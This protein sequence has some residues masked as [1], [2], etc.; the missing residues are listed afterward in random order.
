MSEREQRERERRYRVWERAD[1]P[2][3]D[4]NGVINP[5]RQMRGN[6]VTRE[7]TSMLRQWLEPEDVGSAGKLLIALRAAG[8]SAGGDEPWRTILEVVPALDRDCQ[9]HAVKHPPSGW[10]F[11][12]RSCGQRLR[13]RDDAALHQLGESAVDLLLAIHGW[14]DP[15]VR[16]TILGLLIRAAIHRNQ[17]RWQWVPEGLAG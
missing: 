7:W 8:E 4:E 15:Q 5:S 11:W 13:G 6:G 12:C 2:I 1:D 9:I 16:P 17:L 14:D 10:A 3:W